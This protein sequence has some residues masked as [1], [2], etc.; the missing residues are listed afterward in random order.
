LRPRRL[1]FIDFLL[2]NVV[3][4]AFVFNLTQLG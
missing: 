1:R 4:V 2:L 3:F